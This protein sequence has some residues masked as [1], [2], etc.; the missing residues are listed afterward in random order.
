MTEQ[1]N[2]ENQSEASFTI[3]RIYTKD[4][5]FEAPKTPQVFQK[6]WKPEVNM[7]L[8]SQAEALSDDVYE[9]CLRVT[10]TAKLDDEVAF[11][12]E[13]KQAGIFTIG[14]LEGNQLAHCL[15]AY[16]PN[17]L[18]PYARE[19]VSS[20]IGRGSFPPVTLAPVNFDALFMSYLQQQA[21]E[22]NDNEGSE[23]EAPVQHS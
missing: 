20:L 10:L 14:G 4:V 9:V 23:S 15:Q 2:T 3:Q 11:L 17:I 8:N 1:T 5:S 6:E 19:C 13:V 16:C 21:Q 7:E 18:Y 12:C 22:Q